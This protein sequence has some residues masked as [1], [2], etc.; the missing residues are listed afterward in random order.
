[1]EADSHAM[2]LALRRNE[3]VQI[4]DNRK[5]YSE[6]LSFP[7]GKVEKADRLAILSTLV[8]RLLRDN[9][10]PVHGSIGSGRDIR[11]EGHSVQR[12]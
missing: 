1:M 4:N 9:I 12:E 2:G 8:A 6:K 7:L 5:F 3:C 11:L 10:R